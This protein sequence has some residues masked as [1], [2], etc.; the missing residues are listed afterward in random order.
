MTHT[1]AKLSPHAEERLTEAMER[2][3]RW[4]SVRAGNG[5]GW[6]H[7]TIT[8]KFMAGMPSTKCTLCDGRERIPGWKVGAARQWIECPRCDGKGRIKADPT[9]QCAPTKACRACR[10]TGEINGKTC[11]RCRGSGRA[12]NPDAGVVNPA[13]IRS[14]AP[15]GYTDDPLSQ[16]I[17]W[18]ICTAL[19]ED[20]RAIILV[21]YTHSGT[22]QAK[23]PRCGVSQGYYSRMLSQAQKMI[24]AE[25]KK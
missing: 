10:S 3:A 5:L 15:G 6:P 16:R 18:I 1:H 21:E 2:W 14:T 8:G 11:I 20:H 13:F 24:V 23:A 19:T 12:T 22:Q 7:I 9:S 17:D 25:L 4:R